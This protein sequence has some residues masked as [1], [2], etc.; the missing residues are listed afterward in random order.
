VEE[1]EIIHHLLSF[2]SHT[3]QSI[4]QSINQSSMAG[5]VQQK[6]CTSFLLMENMFPKREKSRKITTHM[7]KGLAASNDH[8][9][10]HMRLLLAGTLPSIRKR[11]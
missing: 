2:C 6:P 8:S 3:N 5:G 10:A 4:N 9:P 7:R 11:K 1:L